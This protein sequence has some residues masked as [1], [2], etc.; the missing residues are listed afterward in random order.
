MVKVVE[1]LELHTEKNKDNVDYVFTCKT[2]NLAFTNINLLNEH[3]RKKHSDGNR[4]YPC[5]QCEYIGSHKEEVMAHTR[6][7]HHFKCNK[8]ELVYKN[9]D[10]L[11]K[12]TNAQHMNIEQSEEVECTLCTRLLK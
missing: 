5:D 2:C 4:V 10:W 7:K 6:S 8:C 1:S 11:M 9:S 12:H 3:E